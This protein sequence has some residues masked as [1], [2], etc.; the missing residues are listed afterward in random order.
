MINYT[1]LL[2]LSIIIRDDL[3]TKPADDAHSGLDLGLAP[4]LRETRRD[5]RE[6]E[7]ATIFGGDVVN[8]QQMKNKSSRE[9]MRKSN[10]TAMSG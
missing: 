4:Q 5:E 8:S 1:L 3:N 7:A 6:E 9:K 10:C 2:P